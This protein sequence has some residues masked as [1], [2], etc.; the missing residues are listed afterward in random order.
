MYD[1]F[2]QENNQE[3]YSLRSESYKEFFETTRYIF[4]NWR[5]VFVILFIVLRDLL[6][7]VEDYVLESQTVTL[8]SY[9]THAY[10]YLAQVRVK[11]L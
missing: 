3:I 9:I 8:E 6:N 7:S 11:T 1:S 10:Y 4:V 5:N 2:K